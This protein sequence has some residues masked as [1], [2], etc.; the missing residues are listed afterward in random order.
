MTS[1]PGLTSRRTM[2]ENGERTTKG[3][4]RERKRRKRGKMGVSGQG[5]RMLQDI[6]RRRSEE[7]SRKRK[8]KSNTR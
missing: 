7:I 8:S 3:E 1:N 6:I 4:R 2:T 5:V